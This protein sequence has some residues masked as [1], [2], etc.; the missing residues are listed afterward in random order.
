MA[1]WDHFFKSIGG[2]YTDWIHWE[3][4]FLDMQQNPSE[5]TGSLDITLTNSID[6]CEYPNCCIKVFQDPAVHT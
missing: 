6:L 1:V 3:K 5:T 2:T 4:T